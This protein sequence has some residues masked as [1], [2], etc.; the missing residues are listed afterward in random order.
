MS[1][2]LYLIEIMARHLI[3][4]PVSTR[5]DAANGTTIPGGYSCLYQ[6]LQRELML[7]EKWRDV[8]VQFRSLQL[9]AKAAGEFDPLEM[10]NEY[11]AYLRDRYEF[12]DLKGFSPRVSGQV[13][14][15]RLAEVFTNLQFE[16]GRPHVSEFAED[17]LA[18]M[19]DRQFFE[20]DWERQLDLLEKRYLRLEATKPKVQILEL[21][22]I[23]AYRKAVIL[24]DPG[25]G[26]TTVTT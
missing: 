4:A 15:L 11:L 17:D 12:L 14:S 16:K 5:N 25:S 20:L 2:L 26:K 18:V 6:E 3:V 23:L 8:I 19:T 24:G 10:K 9:Q 1:N 7:S 13:V 21:A 22:D